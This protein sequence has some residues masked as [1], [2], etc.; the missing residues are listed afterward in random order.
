VKIVLRSSMGNVSTSCPPVDAISGLTTCRCTAPAGWFSRSE[1][2]T[3][4]AAAQLSYND[5]LRLEAAV[6]SVALQRSPMQSELDQSGMTLSLPSAPLYVGDSFTASITASLVGVNYELMAWTISLEYD[7]EVLSLQDQGRY[8]DAIWVDAIVTQQAG[9]LNMIVLKP[10]C[11]P[12]CQSSV[13]GTGIPIATATFTVQSGSEGTH[14]SAVRLRVVSMSNFGNSI[15][16]EGQDALVLDGRDG[17]SANGQVVVEAVAV[18]GLFS[19]FAGGSSWLQNTAPLTGADVSKG[20]TV[21]SVSTRPAD[22]DSSHATASCTSDADSSVLTLSGC[23]VVGTAAASKGD[24]ANITA[25]A[26][27]LAVA[28]ALRVW[29]PSPLSLHLDK[30]ILNRL[31]G[32]AAGAGGSYQGSRLRVLS[33]DLD[34]TP[35]LGAASGVSALL[36]V[37]TIVAL[38]VTAAPGGGVARLT[39]H[40][41]SEGSGAISLVNS[42]TASTSVEVRETAVTVAS[43]YV[44]A[45]TAGDTELALSPEDALTRGSELTAT[46]RLRQL[47]MAE[48]NTAHVFAVATL[49]NPS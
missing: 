39:V 49:S 40:G 17:G 30:A 14:A 2:G 11:A 16:V 33:G 27:G 21:R 13:S 31:D 15:F 38:S 44:G 22:P 18:T 26:S 20:L 36:S 19:Y 10:H 5:K 43:L 4:D 46:Y 29:H 23:I 28:I 48:G 7:A 1:T 3:A 25:L 32:C 24:T 47:L 6:G 9:S 34:I 41:V 8:E 35:L 45:L 12:N 37:P 42:P